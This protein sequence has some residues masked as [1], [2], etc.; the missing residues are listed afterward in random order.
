MVYNFIITDLVTCLAIDSCGWYLISG[1]KDCTAIVWDI[2][3]VHLSTP[4]PYQLL[5]G[6]DEPIS[7]VAISTELDMAVSGSQVNGRHV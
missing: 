1:S 4:K 3:T 7:C 5:H 6:H 2:N